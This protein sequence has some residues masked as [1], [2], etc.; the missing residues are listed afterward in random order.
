MFEVV[1]FFQTK[2]L[3]AA[4]MHHLLPHLSLIHTRDTRPDHNI[5]SFFNQVKVIY[6]WTVLRLA[7]LAN[8]MVISMVRS[9]FLE[10]KVK[11]YFANRRIK[12]S[13]LKKDEEKLDLTQYDVE[14]VFRSPKV[15]RRLAAEGSIALSEGFMVCIWHMTC[16]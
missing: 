1:Y 13:V 7:L 9:P 10:K 5:M 11:K 12:V 2:D 14:L 16:A 4:T 8:V 6:H 15:F 3:F